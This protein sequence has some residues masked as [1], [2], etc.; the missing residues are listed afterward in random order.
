MLKAYD[1]FLQSE[2]SADLAAP[3]GGLERYRY[4]CARCGEEVLL[5]AAN[6]KS[7][8]PHFRHRV[9]NNDVECEN[10]LGQYGIIS[11]DSRS[12][13]SKSERAEFY[14][15][16]STKM[17]YL[18]LRL[19]D[20]EINAYEQRS[21]IFEMRTS[22]REQAFF[23]L[24][25]NNRNFEP[26]APRMIPIEKFSDNYFLSNTHNNVKR[27]Y[28]VFKN[29]SNIPIFFKI[30]SK[31]DSNYKAK[32]VRSEVLYTNVPY[33][34]AFQGQDSIPW[35]NRLPIEIMIDGIFRFETMGREFL[36]MVLT[37]A[38]KTSKVDDL[39]SSWGYRLEAAE[40]LALLWPPASLVDDVSIIESNFAFLYSS[41]E[42]QAYGNINVH[43][44]DIFRLTN[45]ISKVI[46]EPKIKVFKKNA[47]A[48]IK[49]KEQHPS[50]FDKVSMMEESASTYTVQ[51]DSAHFIF[52]RSGA[53]PLGKGQ[54]V[55]LAPRSE[56]TNPRQS[57]G[58]VFVNRSKRSKN[59]SR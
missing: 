27:E 28:G 24:Q 5:A 57:R 21:T 8:A 13:K 23:T 39:V 53:V 58:L 35:D 9:Y 29:D 32:L 41:F 2:V 37:I 16:K 10:Y 55:S 30:H 17:F 1:T 20:D 18:G 36:G 59:L 26:D 3:N 56:V 48:I 33:F 52:N 51:D 49:K 50:A 14:F 40:T 6:S 43:S 4:E 54:T 25:I 45:G 12:R 31:N 11:T 47:E 7:V 22:I 38:N 44:K 19:S 42:L 15:D 46:V 34:I